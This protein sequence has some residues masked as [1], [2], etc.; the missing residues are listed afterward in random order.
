MQRY[1]GITYK[2]SVDGIGML[3]T[4]SPEILTDI[5]NAYRKINP[6]SEITIS[7]R[8]SPDHLKEMNA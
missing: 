5:A 6:K 7:A 8:V 3:Y 4:P 2:V 1:C